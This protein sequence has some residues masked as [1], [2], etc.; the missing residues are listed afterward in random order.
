MGTKALICALAIVAPVAIFAQNFDFGGG[1]TGPAWATFKLNKKTKVK[2][3][4]PNTGVDMILSWYSKNSGITIIKDPTLTGT[5]NIVSA[6]PVTWDEAFSILN[7]TLGLKNFELNKESTYLV[8]RGKNTRQ[9][10]A[11]PPIDFGQLNELVKAGQPQLKVYTIQYANASAVAKVVNDVFSGTPGI[12]DQLQQMFQQFQG[13]GGGFNGGGFNGGGA[14]GRGGRGNRGGGGGGNAFN[15]GQGNR[16][17]GG[18]G[19][20]PG[21][22]GFGGGQPTVKASSDDFSNTVIVNAPQSAQQQ[23]EDLIKKIDRQTTSPQSSKV[24]HLQFASSDQLAPIVQNVLTQNAPTGR[25]GIGTQNV[26]IEQRFQQAFRL[27]SSQASFGTVVSE[28]RTNSIVV[29]ATDDNLKIVEKVITDLDTEVKIENTTYVFQLSNARADQIASLMQQTF[30]TRQ[31][32]NNRATTTVQNN[33]NNNTTNTNRNNNT[34]GRAPTLG[35]EQTDPNNLDLEVNPDGTFKTD[36]MV[37]QGGFFGGGGGQRNTAQGGLSQ[38]TPQIGRDTNG[39]LVNVRDLQNQIT[40]IPDMNT[41]SVIVVGTPDNVE[42]IKQILAQ[43][44]KIPEQVM[45]ETKIIE[46]TL[47]ASSQFGLEWKYAQSNPL[48]AHTGS[49]TGGPD[50]GLQNPPNNGAPLQGF[51]YTLTGG[52][53]SGFINMLQTDTKFQVLS[54]PRIFTSNNVQAEINVSQSIPYVL[55]TRDDGN[56]NLTF[57]YSFLDVGIILTVTPHIASN[58][59]VTMDVTQ[60]AND[61]QGYTDFNAPIVNQRQADTTVSVK[62]GD[63][64]ILGGI[65][66]TNVTSTVKKI[67]LIGDIPL[68]GNLFRS[69]SKDK[70]KTELLV[71]L[72][73][74]IVRDPDEARK[75]KEDEFKKLS[76][77]TQEIL[78]DDARKNYDPDQDKKHT[79]PPPDTTGK[80]GGG[81]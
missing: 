32:V 59:I 27:G 57:N 48:G 66:R 81:N 10:N 5:L 8:I 63:T 7:T 47:D 39:R 16:G 1:Q 6:K 19:F 68:L 28:P 43:L 22:G 62:D 67:P 38:T 46:A 24:F 60:T 29:T 61:L 80:G 71:F 31:G 64:I 34:S 51:R 76:K 20:R 55:S 69:T 52:A 70:N 65:I 14:G 37:Q 53:L 74:R 21:F 78:K 58:G 75:L 35:A 49:A 15:F 40:V 17:G 12:S 13:G 54:T 3:N 72:T 33:R 18:G 25:G 41:N 44:D 4:F 73:P 9:Q 77:P 30:G 50:F 23:V 11:T 2:L 42:L 36:V 45:I 56:G 79:T 26:P